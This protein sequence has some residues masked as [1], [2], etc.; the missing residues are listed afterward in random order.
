MGDGHVD[1]LITIAGAKL[2][3]SMMLSNMHTG[4]TPALFTR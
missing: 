1:E 4:A 2:V 3:I